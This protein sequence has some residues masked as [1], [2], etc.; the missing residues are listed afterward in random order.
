MRRREFLAAGATAL[1]TAV[2]GCS[3]DSAYAGS[4]D[5]PTDRWPAAGYGPAGTSHA[6]AGPDA[7][8]EQWT[9]DREAV[10]PP[11]Y[12]YLGQPAVGDAVYVAGMARGYYDSEDLDSVLAG[13]DPESGEPLWTH[14]V[15]EGITGAPTAIGSTVVVGTGDGR[16]L[17]VEGGE[18]AW[19]TGLD[20][21]GLTPRVFGERLYVPD[22]SG[23]LRC[24]DRSGSTRWTASRSN[25]LE[26]L[27]GDGEPI[28]AA[29]PAVD[30][31]R[32]YAAFSTGD[33]GRSV[34]AAFDHS[35]LRQWRLELQ[36]ETGYDIGPRGIAL[37]D[38]TLYL[39]YGGTIAAVDAEAG[40]LDWE[41]VTGYYTAGPPATDGDRV[42]VAAKNLYAL[43]PADGTELWRVVNE[44]TPRNDTDLDGVPFL[45]RPAVADGTV[46][47]RAAG[48]DPADGTRRWGTDAD[49][50]ADSGKYFTDPYDRV[51]MANLAVTAEGVYLTHATRGVQKFA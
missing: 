3:T 22:A 38:G 12:G 48:F 41:F 28:R 44:S 35:G 40:E 18:T 33:G 50:W 34:V 4:F 10:D 45:A 7:P 6:P 16:L 37:A 11:L 1:S 49:S 24:L 15:P 9:L 30:S 47:L 51:P 29:V 27:L 39:S 43:D 23:A 8:T 25:P 42:Y 14:T 5:R 26:W 32:V 13:I 21:A 36:S 19:T 2:A 17:A 46:Y 20:G 31:D